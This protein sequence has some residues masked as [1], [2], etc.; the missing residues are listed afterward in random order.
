MLLQLIIT[1]LTLLSLDNTHHTILLEHFQPHL[2]KLP[3][4]RTI[5]HFLLKSPFTNSENVP[6]RFNLFLYKAPIT[7]H[8]PQNKKQC[9]SIFTIQ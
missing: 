3:F 6:P 8:F 9:H 4:F 2:R 1:K 5:Y 7:N